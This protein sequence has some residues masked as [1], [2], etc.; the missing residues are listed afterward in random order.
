MNR[1]MLWHSN[2]NISSTMYE[3]LPQKWRLYAMAAFFC[4]S[5]L[6]VVCLQPEMR[7]CRALV[8]RAEQCWQLWVATAL[9]GQCMAAGAYCIGHSQVTN[10]SNS[11]SLNTK[12]LW[13]NLFSAVIQSCV[14]VI[15]LIIS[16]STQQLHMYSTLT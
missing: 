9:L 7:T 13:L 15:Q 6:L 2:V 8:W 14:H 5:V 3:A 10:W 11:V 1:K 16:Q 4:L 12:L